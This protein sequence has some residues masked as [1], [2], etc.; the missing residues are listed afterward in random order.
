MARKVA[1]I[2]KEKTTQRTTNPARLRV[3]PAKEEFIGQ[4][5]LPIRDAARYLGRGEDSLREMIYAGILPVIQVG[6]RSKIWLDIEDL[7]AWIE[8]KKEYMRRPIFED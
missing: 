3:V 1:E 5:L 8:N 2:P 7:N 6:E 4:R